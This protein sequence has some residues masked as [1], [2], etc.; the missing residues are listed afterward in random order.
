MGSGTWL[1]TARG[2]R[3]F[4]TL[5][6]LSD[7]PLTGEVLSPHHARIGPVVDQQTLVRAL[8]HNP[9]VVQN[10]DQVGVAD[11]TETVGYGH[12]GA[13]RGEPRNRLLDQM[14]GFGVDRRGRLV[15]D[16]NG[17]VFE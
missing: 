7:L 6:R 3:E 8:L 10:H 13:L 15:K 9:A 16:Q 4:G 17:G 2:Q 11:G 14:F 5:P 12:G 1:I